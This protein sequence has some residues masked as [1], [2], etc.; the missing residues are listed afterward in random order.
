MQVNVE[1]QPRSR[2][3]RPPP[4]A[5][6]RCGDR[7]RC[8]DR[9]AVGPHRSVA[10]GRSRTASGW[11][12]PRPPPPRGSRR[13]SCRPSSRSS[14]RFDPIPCPGSTPPAG[15]ALGK[16]AA[17][18][19]TLAALSATRARRPASS[20]PA[21]PGPARRPPGWS[22]DVRTRTD[23]VWSPWTAMAYDAEHGPTPARP[24]QRSATPG[25]DPFVAGDVDDVQ[26]K[27]TSADGSRRPASRSTSC[28][29]GCVS[30]E[31]SGADEAPCRR[32]PT[33]R[34]SKPTAE[35]RARADRHAA[36]DHLH[37]APQWGADESLRDCCVEYGEVHAGFVHHT[38]NANNYTAA[39]V[40]AILRGIY[41]YHT[42]SRGWRDIG[43]NYLIDRFGRIWEGRY[44][45]IT[46]PVVGAHTLE[47]QRERL[48][49]LGDRQLRDRAAERRDARR[50]RAAVRL[51]AQPA[52][53]PTDDAAERRRHR[54][55]TRSAGTA[56]PPRPPARASTCTA[57]SRRSSR[58]ADA[59]PAR[60]RRPRICRDPSSATRRRT[61]W[62][63][64]ARPGRLGVARGTAPP[65]FGAADAV[66]TRLRR[67]GPGGR[68][69]RPHRRRRRATCWPRDRGTGVDPG[70]PGVGRRAPSPRPR[71]TTERWADT[72]LFA[73]PGD[74]DRRRQERRRRPR[75][76]DR[77]L[78]LYPGRGRRRL[79]RGAG[80]G[81]DASA[82]IN[83]SA[84]PATSTGT[85]TATCWPAAS[86]ASLRVL[87]G[88]GPA[89]SRAALVWSSD[90]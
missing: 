16:S 50:L 37:A 78:R 44:G 45:G 26:L 2:C 7:R 24:R 48:R 52:R 54:R 51:E 49:R 5:D 76:G 34:R 21:P 53:R 41:A 66:S 32:R 28:R 82:A 79:R 86:P 30:P 9:G 29:P 57:R 14:R 59:V 36:A 11:L 67:H 40:P 27:A 84:R 15:R 64:T 33:R 46:R 31:P 23:G 17:A 13:P 20:S 62:P 18:D 10:S 65:G 47:L 72:D 68:R 58:K 1:S 71:S 19:R 61:C 88:D 85:A 35:L 55:S 74:V 83:C 73:A 56:T 12:R 39:E 42:Q 22:C 75:H 69:R 25:T 60:V 90:W 63:S 38:V 43:Y 3:A 81:A 89:R 8:R 87:F 6:G 70:L 4:P 77:E 80:R